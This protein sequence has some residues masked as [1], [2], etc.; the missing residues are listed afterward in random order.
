MKNM[1]TFALSD[2]SVK[3]MAEFVGNQKSPLKTPGDDMFIVQLDLASSRGT[4]Q[5]KRGKV[6]CFNSRGE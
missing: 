3:T 5:S 4:I 2:S 6:A 1:I